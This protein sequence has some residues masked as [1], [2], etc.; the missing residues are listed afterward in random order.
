MLCRVCVRLA[1]DCSMPAATTGMVTT[2]FS[3]RCLLAAKLSSN[4]LVLAL[5]V[6]VSSDLLL[7]EPT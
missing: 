2:L 4:L 6:D 1:G 5:W 7:D 3:T